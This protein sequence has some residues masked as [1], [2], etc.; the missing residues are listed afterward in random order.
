M[1]VAPASFSA[2]TMRRTEASSMMVLIA[3]QSGSLRCEMVGLRSAGSR[4]VMPARFAFLAF[5][6]RP[7]RP[8]AARQEAS[9]REMLAS[10]ACFHG[11]A[12]AAW[13]AIRRGVLASTS[14]TMRR[15]LAR[16]EPP[17]SVI[18]T[19]ASASRGGFTSVAPHE[20]STW[21]VTPWRARYSVVRCT[22]SV[23][24]RLPCRSATFRTG[25]SFG[26]HSTHR[27]GRRLTLE[28]TNSATSATSAPVSS[29]QSW[30][31]TPASSTPCSTY[32]AISCARTSMQSSSASSIC[33]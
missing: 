7:T 16:S 20:N 11:S 31:V 24:M 13:L 32:R 3:T 2:G 4:A 12:S 33:G 17:V 5:I 6:I 25:E 29:T 27:L 1:P 19:I 23:A 18:S 28:N 26:T 15:L 8:S 21:A 30:P 10:F 22:T 9:I 14:S